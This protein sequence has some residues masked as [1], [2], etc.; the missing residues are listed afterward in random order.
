MKTPQKA[1]HERLVQAGIKIQ[2]FDNFFFVWK[3]DN[4]SAANQVRSCASS[5]D[6]RDI[7]GRQYGAR[8][9]FPF[10][11]CHSVWSCRSHSDWLRWTCFGRMAGKELQ[12][13]SP[14]ILANKWK[15]ATGSIKVGRFLDAQLAPLVPPLKI[16]SIK[17]ISCD[18]SC[19]ELTTP[20]TMWTYLSQRLASHQTVKSIPNFITNHLNVFLHSR[21]TGPSNRRL[22]DVFS[23]LYTYNMRSKAWCAVW[24]VTSRAR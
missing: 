3:E 14:A 7:C 4:N 13:K 15:T 17:L 2:F 21:S 8:A 1:T 16:I 12:K 5:K 24:K 6:V 10:A 20:K 18:D 19:D 22:I 9:H 23:V 11:G